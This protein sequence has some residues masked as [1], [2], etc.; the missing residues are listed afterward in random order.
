VIFLLNHTLRSQVRILR[1]CL[2][3]AVAG[4]VIFG[5]CFRSSILAFVR[6]GHCDC[7]RASYYGGLTRSLKAS[8]GSSSVFCR[9]LHKV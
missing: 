5:I 4:E 6:S 9:V 2:L 7:E 1:A 8:L 3:F